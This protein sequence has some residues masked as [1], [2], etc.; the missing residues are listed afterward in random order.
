[1]DK[2]KKTN[3]RVNMKIKRI[4]KIVLIT[5]GAIFLIIGVPIIINECYKANSGYT[6]VWD[7]ADALGYYGSILGSIIAVATLA[8]TIIFTKK[9]IQR[10]SFI[11]TE[12]EKLSKLETIFGE[13]LDSI[14]PMETMKKV[15][16]NG[17][18]DPT[19]AINIL[20]KYQL[21]CKT[22]CDRLN[23]H[24]NMSDYPKFKKIIESI[25][26]IS[27]EFVSISQGEIDQ[28]SDLRLWSHRETSLKM[29]RNEEIIP[30]SFL[31]K[32]IAFSKDIVEKTNAIDYANI[33]KT[34]ATLNGNFVDLYETKFRGLLQLYGATFEES[35]TEIHKK[36]DGIL[37]IGRK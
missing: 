36:A 5:L 9:Q 31:P 22:A 34:I 28:Y 17:F 23:A 26:S 10:E 18:I 7:G 19:K 15:M 21:N 33:E 20:Q 29:L 4:A 6:T 35:K 3:E 25:A 32:D 12:T 14:N 27:E 24:L 16:D 2:G 11:R 1:M 37:R 8:I 13:I 30:G